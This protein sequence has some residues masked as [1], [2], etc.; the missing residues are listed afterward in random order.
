MFLFLGGLEVVLCFL[1]ALLVEYASETVESLLMGC[2]T[3]VVILL[4]C[5][6]HRTRINT[7]HNTPPPYT[8]TSYTHKHLK[9]KI[10]W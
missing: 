10:I 3:K 2:A 1:S 7:S 6:Y 8:Y 5:L 4:V 9:K